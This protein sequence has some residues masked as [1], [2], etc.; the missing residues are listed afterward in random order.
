MNRYLS[1][2]NGL[3]N[4]EGLAPASARTVF[5]IARPDTQRIAI[6]GLGLAAPGANNLRELRANLLAGRSGVRRL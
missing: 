2:R 3:G 4:F 6:T 5:M 1:A